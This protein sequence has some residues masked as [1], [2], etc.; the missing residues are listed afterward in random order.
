MKKQK[1]KPQ[2][3]KLVCPFCDQPIKELPKGLELKEI[4]KRANAILTKLRDNKII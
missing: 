2:E 3:S 4:V 1:N